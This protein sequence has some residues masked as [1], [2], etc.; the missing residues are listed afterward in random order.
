METELSMHI[1][2]LTFVDDDRITVF[3]LFKVYLDVY[4]VARQSKIYYNQ[5]HSLATDKL[6]SAI[7]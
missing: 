7:R 4:R 6:H 2:D 3:F 1:S 5:G